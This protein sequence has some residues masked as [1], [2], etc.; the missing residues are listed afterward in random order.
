MEECRTDLLRPEFLP[1]MG[2]RKAVVNA[3]DDGEGLGMTTF[4]GL[5]PW[6]VTP[7]ARS[8][9]GEASIKGCQ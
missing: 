7:C 6:P 3:Q 2:S 9:H 8:A 5:F 4:R 1:I